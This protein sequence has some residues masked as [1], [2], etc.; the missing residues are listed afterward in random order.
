MNGD[1]AVAL[2]RLWRSTAEALRDSRRGNALRQFATLDDATLRDCGFSRSELNASLR[3]D[4]PWVDLLSPAMRSLG[5]DPVDVKTKQPERSRDLGRAYT[6]CQ[7]RRRCRADVS[8]ERFAERYRG[9]C[10][11]RDILHEMAE[12]AKPT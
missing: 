9:Y 10:L 5:I 12:A 3:N 8:A 1:L 2:G 4:L 7:F 6:F 11:N